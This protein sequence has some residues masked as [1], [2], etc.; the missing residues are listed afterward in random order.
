MDKKKLSRRLLG[1]SLAL[2]ALLLAF[3]LGAERGSCM[4][5]A[6]APAPAG[7]ASLQLPEDFCLYFNE[8]PLPKDKEGV[9]YLSQSMERPQW[10]GGLSSNLEGA[11]LFWAEDELLA[12]KA[13][14]IRRGHVFTLCLKKG[15][16]WVALP[17][18][19]TG[20]P[21]MSLE[22][23][24]VESIR[25]DGKETQ[26]YT[27]QMTLFDPD[28]G[29]SYSVTASDVTYR[30]RGAK[31][32]GHYPKV[33]YKLNLKDGT[34]H[35][36]AEP[37]LGMPEDDDWMI[38][39][40]YT[41]PQKVR[42]QIAAELWNQLAAENEA[43]P[44]CS[45]IRYMELILD[46]EYY[47]LVGLMQRTDAKTLGLEPGD[48][49][50]KN[51]SLT[52]GHNYEEAPGYTVLYE[53]GAMASESEE[54]DETDGQVDVTRK[55]RLVR[56][57]A[58]L[59]A[60]GRE[61]EPLEIIWRCLYDPGTP[62]DINAIRESFDLENLIDFA[63]FKQVTYA[64]D[65]EPN[66]MFFSAESRPEGWTIRFIP[67]DM[68][69]TFGSVGWQDSESFSRFKE[70]GAEVLTDNALLERLI[71]ADPDTVIPMVQARWARLRGGVF[72]TQS[73][74]NRFDAALAP[75]LNSGAF[76]RDSRRWPTQHNDS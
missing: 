1:L 73:I 30:V 65:N 54:L 10:E 41:D 38:R 60:A 67:W 76:E 72:D 16:E 18:A 5:L 75:L 11:E 34:G 24:G 59:T 20:L 36:R 26:L 69:Y 70:E 48:V 53:S 63:L 61:W 9:W 66:N 33:G 4:G 3:I 52:L 8:S 46:G 12:D 32:A 71:A 45:Q 50:Y 13:E 25:K 40:L 28:N 64:A 21:L 19:V 37:L 44:Y 17:L 27:G 22:S 2:L 62:A 58:E 7:Q 14:A 31:S 68:D 55:T 57:P 51:T 35:N 39:C 15:E 74:L 56:A 43:E 42:E 47:G 49:L 29:V 6:T 23:D